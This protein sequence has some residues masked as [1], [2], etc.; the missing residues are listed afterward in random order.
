MG[1][2]LPLRQRGSFAKVDHPYPRWIVRDGRIVVDEQQRR[3][4]N[5]ISM[6]PRALREHGQARGR[7]F[8]RAPGLVKR[9]AC[10]TF[11]HCFLA[12][13]S[14]ALERFATQRAGG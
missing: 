1:E 9:S 7:V 8:T 2:P 12:A 6:E 5:L 3:G 11:A 10:W 13:G 4:H 14:P